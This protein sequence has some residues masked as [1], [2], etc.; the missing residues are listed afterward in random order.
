MVTAQE[1]QQIGIALANGVRY[2]TPDGRMLSLENALTIL[3]TFCTDARISII[4]PTEPGAA[5]AI[6]FEIK[7]EKFSSV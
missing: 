5:F 7:F 4:P 2:S 3:N 6:K 1:L